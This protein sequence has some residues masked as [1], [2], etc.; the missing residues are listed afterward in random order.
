MRYIRTREEV[1]GMV[2]IEALACGTPVI[3]YKTGGS[4]E[5]IKGNGVGVMVDSGIES[6]PT[7]MV[8][9]QGNVQA[10][11]D[12]IKQMKEHPIAS[13]VCRKR[14]KDLFD[15]DKCFEEYI[16]LYEEILRTRS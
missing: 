15:K 7:G 2:N 14:A 12:A 3:T 9:E 13:E 1:F 5:A 4:P 16:T 10:L 8:V 11:A 6:Y